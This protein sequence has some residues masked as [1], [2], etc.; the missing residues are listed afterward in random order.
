MV[1]CDRTWQVRRI[2]RNSAG[3]YDLSYLSSV[4]NTNDLFENRGVSIKSIAKIIRIW[5]EP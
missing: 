1:Q 2:N 3:L 4:E 5:S